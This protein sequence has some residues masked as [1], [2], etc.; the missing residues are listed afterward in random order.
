MSENDKKP[1]VPTNHASHA[2]SLPLRDL[3]DTVEDAELILLA[4]KINEVVARMEEGQ[5]VSQE[6]LQLEFSV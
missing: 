6:I 1:T 3:K 5:N 4:E 2:K